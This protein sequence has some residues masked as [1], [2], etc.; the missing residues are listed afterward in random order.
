MRLLTVSHFYKD[1]G[2]GIERVAAQLCREFGRAGHEAVWAA[3]DADPTPEAPIEAIPLPCANPIERFVGLP[4]PVP[5]PT[6]LRRLDRAISSC[7]AMVIHDALYLTSIAAMIIAR[8]RRKPVVLIQHIAAIPFASL[9]MR[10]VMR[11]ANWIVTRPMMRAADRLVF[12]SDTVR[13]ALL[14]DSSTKPFLL[15]HNGVD[16]AIFNMQSAEGRASTRRRYGL[17]EAGPIALFVGRFVEKKGLAILR[18]LAIRQPDLRIVLVGTGPIRPEDWAL[19]NIRVLGPLPQDD[20]SALYGAS[21]M[22][23]LPSAGEGYPLVVQEAMACGLPIICGQDSAMADPAARQW[24]HGVRIDL[25]DVAGSADRC[26]AA[27]A[28]LA[29]A[30][31]DRGAMARYAAEAYSWPAMAAA[32]L[33][34]VQPLAE[35]QRAAPLRA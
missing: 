31:S 18:A 19:P 22:L 3:S 17:P 16:P 24:L 14:G 25:A 29:R 33:Y 10:A 13:L 12:I 34:A 30:P 27:I 35:Q 32:I 11:L 9:L 2:G 28:A 8:R 21:D 6:A 20:I 26:D 5:G 1:H 4:M 23:L 7:D 15:L